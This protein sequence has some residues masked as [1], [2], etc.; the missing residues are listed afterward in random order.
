M[1]SFS[2]A[3]PLRVQFVFQGQHFS[4]LCPVTEGSEPSQPRLARL[5]G[6][7][8]QAE[9]PPRQLTSVWDAAR[10]YSSLRGETPS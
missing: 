7:S 4:R 5:E 9:H 6:A 2:S 1:V 8:H 10:I 3:L